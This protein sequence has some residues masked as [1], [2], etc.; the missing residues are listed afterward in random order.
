MQI[1]RDL[2]GLLNSLVNVD[3]D[4]LIAILS[5]EAEAAERLAHSMRTRTS[6]QRLKRER[7]GEHAL[8]QRRS[9][10]IVPTDPDKRSAEP[11]AP[12]LSLT[13]PTMLTVLSGGKRILRTLLPAR[14]SRLNAIPMS[15]GM[16]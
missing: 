16:E 15:F 14:P 10:Q 9:L 5:S 12:P 6:P 1:M 4:S 11:H 7:A 2:D 13:L 3:R 8:D